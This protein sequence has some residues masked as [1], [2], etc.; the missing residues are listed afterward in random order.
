MEKE[1]KEKTPRALGKGAAGQGGGENVPSV[2]KRR[3]E[4]IEYHPQVSEY[5]SN[6][7][8]D[9]ESAIDARTV[10]DNS[11]LIQ[12]LIGKVASLERAAKTTTERKAA[13]HGRWYGI[14][15]RGEEC[16]KCGSVSVIQ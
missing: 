3:K 2:A 9:L 15:V 6:D 8:G 7:E 13:E 1:K 12:A 16:L 10:R 5:D 14:K 4:T 11:S